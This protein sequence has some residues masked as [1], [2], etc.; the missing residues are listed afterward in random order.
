[1]RRLAA[2]ILL[3][4][5]AATPAVQAQDGPLPRGGRNAYPNP[6]AIIAAEIA[7]TRR[8]QEKGQ[9]T[10]MRETA[11]DEAIMLVPGLPLAQTW[12]KHRPEPGTSARWQPHAVSSS[13]DGSLMIVTGAWSGDDGQGA[14]A[15]V[16]QRQPKGG[17]KWLV[18]TAT[19]TTAPPAEPEML[20]A[21]IAD[22]SLA[23]RPPGPAAG[24]KPVAAASM[25]PIVQTGAESRS[26]RSRDGTLVWRAKAKADGT[27]EFGF[28]M[29]QDGAMKPVPPPV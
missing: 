8:A 13:C 24:E 18:R 19:T 21:R 11:A 4:A 27:R 28:D 6:S 26:G 22:C 3:V 14:Y 16:W 5:F 15:A 9:W 7:L 17:Y 1:M 25:P 2:A 20:A 29:A 23:T 12:L 10:A